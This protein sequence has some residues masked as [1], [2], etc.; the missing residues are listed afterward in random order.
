[1]K[2]TCLILLTMSLAACGG[3]DGNG[4]AGNGSGAAMLA[5]SGTAPAGTTAAAATSAQFLASA[6]Q[7][8]LAEIQLGQLALQR[9]T[10]ADV[11][12][13]AQRMIDQHTALNN[14]ITSL[15]QSKNITLPTAPTADQQAE[16]TRLSGL[17]GQEFDLAY[18][19]ANVTG[20]RKDVTEARTQAKSGDDPTVKMLAD[21]ALPILE[22][23]LAVAEEINALL[24]PSFFLTKSYEDGL[25]EIQLAQLALQKATDSSVRGFAQR[26][27]DDHTQLNNQISTLAQQRNL[28]LATDLPADKQQEIS[29]LSA[30]SGADFDKAYMDKNVVGHALDVRLARQQSEEGTDG[31]VQSLAG[32]ALPTLTQHLLTAIQIDRSIEPG[33]LFTAVR[34]NRAELRLAH[35]ALLKTTN[36]IVRDFA[37]RMITDHTS[38]AQQ[39]TQL[40]QQQGLSF[41][42]IMSPEQTLDFVRLLGL[43]GQDFD[44]AYMEI[45]VRIHKA[46]VAEFTA[47]T[48]QGTTG[49]GTS[50]AGGNA[51]GT[52][53]SNANANGAAG[54]GAQGSGTI[55]ADVRSFAQNLLPVLTQHLQLAQQ[56]LD[57]LASSASTGQTGTGGTGTGGTG[58]GGTGT[59]QTGTGQTGTGQTGTGGTGTGGSNTG[60]ASTG[61]SASGAGTGA[62]SGASA[63]SANGGSASATATPAGQGA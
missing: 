32:Q 57:Q 53:T 52:G 22:A 35:L 61:A 54:S 24:D 16:A 1:M 6:Y 8:G 34:D 18:M 14:E 3:G 7:D 19:Q 58:T 36:N 21:N 41:P 62:S 37:N 13:F 12:T 55:T 28:T 59:G 42:D 15:A 23:H 26:M 38:A 50:N 63:T 29:D 44:R 48:Q 5:D 47:V 45:N 33:F 60:G 39:L 51:G 30:L 25:F 17:S 40:T 2:K 27:V 11:K 46:D 49:S 10:N 20:H 31:D 43:T 9:A 56:I 4:I